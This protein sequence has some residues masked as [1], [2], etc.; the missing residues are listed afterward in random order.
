M[1]DTPVIPAAVLVQPK[2][3]WTSK[4]LWFGVLIFLAS[5]AQ[6]TG[7]LHLSAQTLSIL[8]L[9]TA[10]ATFVLRFVTG[11]PISDIGAYLSR[12]KG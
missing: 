2:S 1:T 9:I 5:L 12:P 4:T 3:R 7:Y 8:G 6:F 10:L 11:A